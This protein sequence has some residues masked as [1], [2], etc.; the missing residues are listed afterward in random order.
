M[1]T[2][3]GFGVNDIRFIKDRKEMKRMIWE[4]H[5]IA[6]FIRRHNKN[7]EVEKNSTKQKGTQTE[8][9]KWDGEIALQ[10]ARKSYSNWTALALILWKV[11]KITKLPA[12]VG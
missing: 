1:S 9:S 6:N 4:K 10:F 8:L 2:L 3:A 11:W 7:N 5:G 12:V